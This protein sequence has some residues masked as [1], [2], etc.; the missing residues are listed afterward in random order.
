ML[1]S[2][3]FY[4]PDN[5]SHLAALGELVGADRIYFIG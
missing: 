1:V 3:W 4:F 2:G 5:E